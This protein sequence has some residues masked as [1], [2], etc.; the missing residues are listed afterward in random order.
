M[1]LNQKGV[2]T[3]INQEKKGKRPGGPENKEK[4][5]PETTLFSTP[6]LYLQINLSAELLA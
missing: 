1:S 5:A 2:R 3:T 6:S 4:R